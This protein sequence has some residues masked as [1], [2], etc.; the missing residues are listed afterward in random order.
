MPEL[1]SDDAG[2]SKTAKP[3]RKKISIGK[4]NENEE[5]GN[6]NGFELAG[7]F[8]GDD[9]PSAQQNTEQ[10]A[11]E[12]VITSTPIVQEQPVKQGQ[13]CQ[14][15]SQNACEIV[16]SQ[17]QEQPQNQNNQQWNRN[18]NNRF[19]NR[20]EP[21]E[22]YIINTE[23]VV[24]VNLMIDEEM[25]PTVESRDGDFPVHAEFGHRAG[26]VFVSAKDCQNES[27]GVGAKRDQDIRKERMG[28]PA[29]LTE[30]SGNGKSGLNTLALVH[31]DHFPLI[32]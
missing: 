16:V 27:K 21:E 17:Q 22:E 13:M 24:Y 30:I 11:N 20:R 15:A 32:G 14:V 25:N 23:D 12:V 3:R 26:A 9:T 7:N 1:L 4:K 19:N 6:A 28:S 5:Q 10:N 2:E 29:G 31:G 18:R 8:G